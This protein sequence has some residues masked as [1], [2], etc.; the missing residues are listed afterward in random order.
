MPAPGG[1]PIKPELDDDADIVVTAELP[2]A[3]YVAFAH[4]D[5]FHVSIGDTKKLKQEDAKYLLTLL[6]VGIPGSQ[7]TDFFV[8]SFAHAY[9]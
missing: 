8:E 3:P 4:G 7:P 5:G 6:G 1:T 9:T 2:V